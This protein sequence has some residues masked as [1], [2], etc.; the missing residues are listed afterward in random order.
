VARLLQG[1]RDVP[2][3]DTG[4]VVA[5][6]TTVSRLLTD[7]PRIAELD[8]NPLLADAAGVVALDARVR[9]SASA[10]GGAAS[11]A[12]RP[13][14]AQFVEH[15]EWRGRTLTLRPIRPEDEAQHLAFLAR[16]DPTD[17]RMR[18]FYSRRSIERSELAR[19]TQIDYE[20]EMAFI[21]TA[22]LEGGGEE[23]LGV[24]RAVIDLD[25]ADAE[26]GIVVRSDLKGGGLGEMLMH[27][28]I[29]H[30][31]ERGTQRL[32]ATVLA[33]NARMLEL[34]RDLGFSVAPPQPGEDTV[35]IALPLH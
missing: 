28:L 25:N 3:A 11:F 17:I 2:P 34:A 35:N 15:I 5:V 30:L 19:L 7:E 10:P 1:W 22:P 6:L 29:G 32:V 31:R 24:V 21:A 16:L 8:I 26:F 9:V 13:Y 23:T 33:E 27:K 4:A 14:P 12:I 18:I 20:R